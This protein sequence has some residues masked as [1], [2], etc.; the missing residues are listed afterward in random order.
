MDAIER[1]VGR[2]EPS[3]RRLRHVDFEH[4]VDSI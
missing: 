2:D 3:K 4:T 1:R